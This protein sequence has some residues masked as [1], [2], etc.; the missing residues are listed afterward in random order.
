MFR[1]GATELCQG[2]VIQGALFPILDQREFGVL[3]TP[4]CDLAQGKAD[5]VLLVAAFQF[6]DFVGQM[7]FGDPRF[8][9]DEGQL[10]RTPSKAALNSLRDKLAAIQRNTVPRY[11]WLERIPHGA[12]P[13]VVDFQYLSCLVRAEA[14]AFVVIANLD[15]PYRSAVPAR[16]ASYAGRIGVPDP[17]RSTLDEARSEVLKV[18]FES[19][20]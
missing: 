7:A 11:H 6:D 12:G 16:Y 3:L 2:A 20:S 5:T 18:M 4:E 19:A 13:F 9:D 10:T 17:D 1:E 14:D 15:D 8:Q